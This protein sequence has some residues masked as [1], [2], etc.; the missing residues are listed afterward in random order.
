VKSVGNKRL[1]LAGH[2]GIGHV[3]SHSGFVQDDSGGFVVVGSIIKGILGADTC[4]RAVD[5][6]PDTNVIKVTTM[7]GGIGES[8]PRRGIT[9]REA[10]LIRGVIGQDALFCQALAVRTIGRMYGQGVLETP[11]ALEAAL[12]NSVVDTFCKKA[13]DRFDVTRESLKTND[14]LIG[15]MS[16]EIEGINTS[17][18]ITVNRSSA[19][20]GPAEDLEGNVALGSKGELMRRL[21]M[22][23]CPTII[24]EGKVYLPSMS[25]ELHQN[26]FL[27]RAQRD[28]DNMV[29]AKALYDAAQELGYPVILLDDA[30]PHR[31]GI[32]EQ[33]TIHVAEKIIESAEKLKKAGLASEKVLILAELARLV[34]QDAGAITFMSNKLHDVVRGVGM[35]PGTSAV[36]SMLVTKDYWEHWKIPLFEEQDVEMAKNIIGLAMSKVASNIDAAYD[37]VNKFYVSLDSLEQVIN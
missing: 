23:R 15:G 16:T 7:G 26:T 10:E 21:D 2:A 13:P 24:L 6:D 4:V 36:L 11:V 27:V 37:L 5:V 20:L 22:V 3:H 35:M 14:G 32:M 17:V 31:E 34:S 28:L 29:V 25:D 18:L 9:P 30:L 1:G 12:A 33:N 8:F 19:G